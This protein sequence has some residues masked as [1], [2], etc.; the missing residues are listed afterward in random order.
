MLTGAV[1]DRTFVSVK[2]MP[3]I[4]NLFLREVNGTWNLHV[5]IAYPWTRGIMMIHTLY[6]A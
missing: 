2:R 4:L 5:E 1:N 3:N 6:A